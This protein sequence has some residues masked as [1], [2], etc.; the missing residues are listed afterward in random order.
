[1]ANPAAGT[2]ELQ[3]SLDSM[4]VSMIKLFRPQQNNLLVSFADNLYP[5]E[6]A[7]ALRQI[8]QAVTT[9]ATARAYKFSSLKG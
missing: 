9:A 1:M 6:E 4:D 7:T 8:L 3:I 2:G 5:K